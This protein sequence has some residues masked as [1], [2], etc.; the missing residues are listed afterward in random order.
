MLFNL[1]LQT[2]V[3]P[4]EW[5]WANVVPI[6]KKG[7]IQ[8]VSN[9][10]PVSLLPVI[11]KILEKCVHEHI[12]NILINDI[13]DKQHGFMHQ[14]STATQLVE[15]YNDVYNTVDD[16]KQVDIVYLDFTKAF[17][18][19][20]HTLLLHK[21]TSLG[22]S[23]NLLRWLSN[24]L[25]HRR[26]R[27][28]LE[29][30]N[31]EYQLVR[32]GVPQGS[33]LGPLLFILYINDIF[34]SVNNVS[35]NLCLYADDSKISKQINDINDC[36]ALQDSLDQLVAWSTVWGMDFN[37]RKCEIMSVKSSKNKIIFNYLM[38]NS[39]LKRVTTFNDLGIHICDDLS[40]QKHIDTCIS[41][42]N[43]R[44]GLVKRCLG[45][46]CSKQT[47]LTS[48]I[49]LVRP[50]IEYNTVVWFPNSKKQICR[51]ESVQR[52]ATKYVLSDYTINYKER[53]I[54]CN[55]LP[56]S[57]RRQYLDCIFIY[58][59]LKG[60]NVFNI[61]NYIKFMGEANHQTRLIET[62]DELMFKAVRTKHEAY[63]K[64]L[65]RR[66]IFFW[67]K[68]PYNVR[69]LELTEN[70]RNTPFKKEI[71]LWL[72]KYFIDNFI[73]DNVCSWTVACNCNTCKLT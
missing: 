54:L 44:L 39:P 12:Y 34:T 53:L 2:G 21:L 48:Y 8:D 16:N 68:I 42:A 71:R 65:T 59:S 6:F 60:L 45:Y 24:Y 3:V 50:L 35:V 18:C 61:L 29:G 47:K 64:F 9:Y 55:L 19:I 66:I 15:F 14:R 20:P 28:V 72:W 67:N 25:S 70:S 17:D 7:D 41:K 31:S 30:I 11:G 23:G 5:K 52:R 13:N 4:S 58:N 73:V 51:I 56:L 37:I 27:V 38:H 22:F 40:W 69:S 63:C 1:S 43:K 26:Q 32:S 57:M 62:Q 36:K 10:R 33:I 49:S 46:N